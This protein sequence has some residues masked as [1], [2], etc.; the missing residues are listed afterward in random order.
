MLKIMLINYLQNSISYTISKKSNNTQLT[1]V[2]YGTDAVRIKYK[3]TPHAVFALNWT[4]DGKQ[5]VLPTNYEIYGLVTPLPTANPV[6]PNIGNTHFFWNPEAKVR[7]GSSST[8]K[9]DTYQDVVDEYIS[10]YDRYLGYD[11]GYL[12]LAELYKDNIQNRFGGQTEEAFENNQWLPAGEPYRIVNN[13]GTPLLTPLN[14][15]YTEGDTFFQR[16][17]CMKVYP[18]TLEDQNSVNDIV[19]FM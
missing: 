18:S 7:V 3:S 1:S 5:I 8:I 16:Y 6:T 9:D 17:D 15:Y 13:D 4:N 12:F 11:L 10:T 19:S 2:A 14:I